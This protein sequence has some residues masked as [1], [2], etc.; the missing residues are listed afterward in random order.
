MSRSRTGSTY[1]N[2][3]LTRMA[4]SMLTGKGA[5]P[6]FSLEVVEVLHP[7]DPARRDRVLAGALER[8]QLTEADAP[9][10]QLLPRR[11][12]QRQEVPR[13]PARVARGCPAVVIEA[14]P[15]HDRARIMCRTAADH[16]R[17]AEADH[18]AAELA[19]ITPIVGPQRAARRVQKVVRPATATGRPVV[20]PGL[21][22]QRALRATR[23]QAARHHRTRCSSTDNDSVHCH[24]EASRV[25]RG[26][27]ATTEIPHGPG[28]TQP[29]PPPLELVT[30]AFEDL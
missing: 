12:E 20:R 11:G 19:R 25:L 26:Q 27:P 29:A 3:L 4:P 30:P 24:R 13:R 7:W 9:H 23:R 10:P 1:A 21:Q 15:E 28:I 17:T 8:G 5:T 22:Q 2:A 16:P 18:P 14:A 6:A